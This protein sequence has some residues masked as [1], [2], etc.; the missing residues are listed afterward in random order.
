M[1]THTMS[2]RNNLENNT[3]PSRNYTY[4]YNKSTKRWYRK[5]LTKSTAS[6]RPLLGDIH[7]VR[8]NGLD[9]KVFTNPS[10]AKRYTRESTLCDTHELLY[11]PLTDLH[12]VR[13]KMTGNILKPFI[14]E[15]GYPYISVYSTM[16]PL[17]RV[18]Y[19]LYTGSVIP[20]G[21]LLDHIDGNPMNWDPEN[22]RVC[23]HSQNAMNKHRVPKVNAASGLPRGI[24]KHPDG[25]YVARIKA[26]GRLFEK[27][28]KSLDEA[29]EWL[30][31]ARKALHGEFAHG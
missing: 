17:H 23:T 28:S 8:I 20:E 22:L 10:T 9:H 30:Q 18:I 7:T 29:I 1:N 16:M 21:L 11:C 25:R 5:D 6:K 12:M 31:A 19:T 24:R 14:N 26:A 15:K 27:S 4:V 3:N 13:N 2:N